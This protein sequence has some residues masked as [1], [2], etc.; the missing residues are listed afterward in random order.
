MAAMQY[1][2][3]SFIEAAKAKEDAIKAHASK[4]HAEEVQPVLRNLLEWAGEY[5][6]STEILWVLYTVSRD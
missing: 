6:L 2:A 1:F 4:V 3:A 5:K